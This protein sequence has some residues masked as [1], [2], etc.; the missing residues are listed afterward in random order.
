MYKVKNIYILARLNMPTMECFIH[1]RR[2]VWIGKIASMPFSR[3]PC[4]FS[5]AWIS[6][7]RPTGRPNLT[8]PESFL[9][10][11]KK[12]CHEH[13]GNDFKNMKC[14]NGKSE[15]WLPMDQLP[16]IKRLENVILA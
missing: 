7:P 8:T 15:Q 3:N 6:N 10:S 11:R 9:K 12:F 5:K 2:L 16:T 13:G 14:P 4:I 1:F